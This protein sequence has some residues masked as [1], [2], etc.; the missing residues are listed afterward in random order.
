MSESTD[1]LLWVEEILAEGSAL[2][3]VSAHEAGLG[4]YLAK[5]WGPSCTESRTDALGNQFYL[6][7]GRRGAGKIL[8]AAHADEI[9]L[10]VTA[11]DEKGFIRFAPVGGVDERALPAQAVMVHGRRDLPG[12]ICFA[13]A[14]RLADKPIPL[15]HLAVDIGY[16]REETLALVRPGDPISFACEFKLLLNHTGTGKALDDRAGLVVLAVCLRDLTGRTHGPDVL[17]VAT[18]QE[19]VGCRGAVTTAFQARPDAAIAVDVTHAQSPD[20]KQVTAQL[21]RGPVIARGPNL[22]PLL[23]EYLE[24]LAQSERIPLQTEAIPRATGT[25]AR[26]LQ[27]A[28]QGVPTAL[29]SVPLRYMHTPVETISAQDVLLAGKL[30]AAAIAGL[31]PDLQELEF[32]Y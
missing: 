29:I 20:A 22:H 7:P 24:E 27:L 5:I 9:G 21:G 12:V 10:V 6:K 3:G 16:G 18:A 2:S 11:V 15:A 19:E 1:L 23:T 28:G 30:L 31:S 26:A 25:D 4:P 32:R 17:A 13:A 8:L 14:K